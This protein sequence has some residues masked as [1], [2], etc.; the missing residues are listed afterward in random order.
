MLY[1]VIFALIGVSF[2]EMPIQ[3]PFQWFGLLF[4]SLFDLLLFE[5]NSLLSLGTANFF[6]FLNLRILQIRVFYF[7]V[8]TWTAIPLLL[9]FPKF[10]IQGKI[11]N[12]CL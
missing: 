9:Y 5:D 10:Y 7:L 3:A 1:L 4:V 12:I 2:R 11:C 6:F 8:H